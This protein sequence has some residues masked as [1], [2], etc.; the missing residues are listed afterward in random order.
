[1]VGYNIF[2][3]N[4]FLIFSCLHGNLGLLL[5]LLE[6]RQQA[7]VLLLVPMDLHVHLLQ[8]VFVVL[9]AATSAAAE[10]AERGGGG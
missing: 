8:L 1:M 7:F 6:V 2:G 3:R 10:A 9:T 4:N 5:E